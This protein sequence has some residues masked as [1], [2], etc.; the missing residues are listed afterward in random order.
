MSKAIDNLISRIREKQAYRG[1]S[2]SELNRALDTLQKD[3][4]RLNQ[5]MI[6]Q[7]RGYETYS[8]TRQLSDPLA[9]EANRLSDAISDLRV[10]IQMRYGPGAPSRLPTGSKDR[11]FFGPRTDPSTG[12]RY[13]N[14]S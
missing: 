4:S 6:D 11:R 3:R 13:S 5:I 10:E 8:Q 1:M 2:A 7:G 12:E 9:T 14:K